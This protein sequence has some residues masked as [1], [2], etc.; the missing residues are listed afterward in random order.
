MRQHGTVID[1]S[2]NGPYKN[3]KT[4]D[5]E[6]QDSTRQNETG[7]N[8]KSDNK[9]TDNAANPIQSNNTNGRSILL[10]PTLLSSLSSSRLQSFQS[11]PFVSTVIVL[12]F[13]NFSVHHSVMLQLKGYVKGSLENDGCRCCCV[14]F[15]CV[16]VFCECFRAGE[17]CPEGCLDCRNNPANEDMIHDLRR[18]KESFIP[19]PLKR[20]LV[21]LATLSTQN[22]GVRTFDKVSFTVLLFSLVETFW[23]L[24]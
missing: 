15:N 3:P 23:S 4:V 18:R 16:A 11:T 5:I 1:T 6:P 2:M 8:Q 22:S 13:N 7:V 20:K 12:L 14:N 17:Y 19:L 9:S 21:Q 10:L 24:Y